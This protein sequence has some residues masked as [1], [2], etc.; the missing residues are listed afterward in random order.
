MLAFS[1]MPMTSRWSWLMSSGARPLF[2][3]SMRTD[4]WLWSRISVPNHRLYGYSDEND[5]SRVRLSAMAHLDARRG[6]QH[7]VALHE[8]GR[9][10]LEECLRLVLVDVADFQL[11]AVRECDDALTRVFVVA[12]SRLGH[13]CWPP[14]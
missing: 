3:K 7:A 1:M 13:F 6:V 11:V 12:E 2:M 5:R 9:V 10:L 4:F 14:K 8:L